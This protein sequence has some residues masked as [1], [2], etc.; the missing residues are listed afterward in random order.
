[1]CCGRRLEIFRWN[2]LLPTS[3]S[4]N[5]LK[6][7]VRSKQSSFC[8]LGLPFDIEDR[9]SMFLRNLG[10]HLL[11]YTPQKIAFFIVS[12]VRTSN[13]AFSTKFLCI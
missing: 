1:V 5:K 10:E 11:D 7:P 9:D 6:N 4:K 12:A 3:G 8:L 2:L 13:P